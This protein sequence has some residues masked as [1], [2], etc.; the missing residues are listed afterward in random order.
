[1]KY[2]WVVG[3]HTSIICI[4]GDLKF[5]VEKHFRV[6]YNDGGVGSM[7]ERML[8]GSSPW[9]ELYMPPIMFDF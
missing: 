6:H 7:V 5:S 4:F 2:M 8:S 1:M 3:T 9:D